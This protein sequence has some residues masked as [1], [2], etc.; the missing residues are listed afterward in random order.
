MGVQPW[1]RGDYNVTSNSNVIRVSSCEDKKIL[2]TERMMLGYIMVSKTQTSFF[3][4][5]VRGHEVILC[6]LHDN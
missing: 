4:R 6:L 3:G 1:K 5:N 2:C